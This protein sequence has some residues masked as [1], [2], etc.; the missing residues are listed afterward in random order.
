MRWL[1]LSLL[2]LNI[3]YVTWELNREHTP[4]RATTALPA[5][6]ESIV[7]LSE[8]KADKPLDDAPT[9]AQPTEPGSGG[10]GRGPDM[11]AA[12]APAPPAADAES[13]SADAALAVVA[14]QGSSARDIPAP[15]TEQLARAATRPVPAPAGDQCFTLGPFSEM[16][17]LRLV[18]REIKDYVVEASFRSKEEQ[19][20]T[21]F[22]VYIKSAGSKQAA[23]AVIKQLNSKNIKDHFIIADGPHKNAVS[24]GY[25]SEKDRAYRYAA[26][27]RKLGFDA[28]AEPV[29]RNYTI[30]W[31]D[32]RIKG[33]EKIPQN[34]IDD[35]L[36]GTAR[37]LVRAC[38]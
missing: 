28:I 36:D 33:G 7:L 35:H 32:Y 3:A 20:Q 5:G 25:F 1:F 38:S 37:R 12:V 13:S 2:V 19:E 10:A 17:T 15:A 6:V 8:L 22:R 24:L 21:R 9:R 4:R 23:K 29:F 34:I 30:Y 26:R 18:T 14:E 31:L 11:A 16:K 27:V